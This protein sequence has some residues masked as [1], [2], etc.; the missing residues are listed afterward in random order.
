MSDC[1][2]P[3]RLDSMYVC[4]KSIYI[5]SEFIFPELILPLKEMCESCLTI[6]WSRYAEYL[7]DLGVGSSYCKACTGKFRYVYQYYPS[8]QL[9]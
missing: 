3:R 2:R 1:D 7:R 6:H 5:V 9:T 4:G 8:M